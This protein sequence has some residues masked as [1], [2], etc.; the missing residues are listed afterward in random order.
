MVSV[1]W[2]S[3]NAGAIAVVELP[4]SAPPAS[5]LCSAQFRAQNR[6]APLLELLDGYEAFLAPRSVAGRI[7]QQGQH[8]KDREARHRQHGVE[9]AP[10][11]RSEEHTSELQSRENLVCRLLLE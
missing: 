5:S 4:C 6:C 9:R 1:A 7:G 3:R 8:E 10:D 2:A 11:L